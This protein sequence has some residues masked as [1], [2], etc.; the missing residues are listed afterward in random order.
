MFAE[1]LD[2]LRH[3]LRLSFRCDKASFHDRRGAQFE[4][5]SRTRGVVFQTG[6]GSATERPRLLL[7]MVDCKL[8]QSDETGAKEYAGKLIQALS[9]RQFQAD[10]VRELSDGFM[11]EISIQETALWMREHLE[12]SGLGAGNGLG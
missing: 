1:G 6:P 7:W 11:P 12:V 5:P 3:C 4:R 10:V 9:P 8:K 2:Y